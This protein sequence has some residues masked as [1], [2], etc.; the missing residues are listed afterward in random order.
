MRAGVYAS[1]TIST[2]KN[3]MDVLRIVVTKNVVGASDN[4]TSNILVVRETRRVY[5]VDVGGKFSKSLRLN[6]ASLERAFSKP[7]SKK[8]MT[9]MDA[10]VERFSKEMVDWLRR[11][12]EIDTQRRWE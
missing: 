6:G 12:K 9:R 4:N 2:L 7:P 5:G 11:L 3:P 8:T 10:L 1:Y